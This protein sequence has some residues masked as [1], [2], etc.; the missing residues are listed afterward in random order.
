[1]TISKLNMHKS[2]RA[3]R[4][5]EETTANERCQCSSGNWKQM[6]ALGGKEA[7]LGKA[8]DLWMPHHAA[9]EGMCK[10]RGWK[11]RYQVVWPKQRWVSNPHSRLQAPFWRA[12]LGRSRLQAQIWVRA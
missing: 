2:T 9:W 5:G 7:V 12:L 4:T 3:N 6:D 10:G 1:M 8:Q 11:E